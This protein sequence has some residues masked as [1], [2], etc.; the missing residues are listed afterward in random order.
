M[1]IR[2]WHECT[3]PTFLRCLEIV[4]AMMSLYGYSVVRGVVDEWP[5]TSDPMKRLVTVVEIYMSE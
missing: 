1:L 4:S 2:R 5:G 3:T